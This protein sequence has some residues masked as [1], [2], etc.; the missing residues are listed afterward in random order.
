MNKLVNSGR[1][2]KEKLGQGIPPGNL[3]FKNTC[4]FENILHLFLNQARWPKA[5][6]PGFLES[7]SSASVCA[8]VCVCVC[9]PPRP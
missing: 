1:Q 2:S 4:L 7:L 3:I 5:S 8:R 6:V 9:T